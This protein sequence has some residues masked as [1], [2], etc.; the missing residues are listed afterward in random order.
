MP[1]GQF[2]SRSQGG[3]DAASARYIHTLLNKVTRFIYPEPDGN[4]NKKK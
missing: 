3:K 2:G 4:K 1:V